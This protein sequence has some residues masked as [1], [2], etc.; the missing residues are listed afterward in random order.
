MKQFRDIAK[1]LE[2]ICENIVVDESVIS[3]KC[4]TLG[5][6]IRD[7]YRFQLNLKFAHGHDMD[8]NSVESVG[9][10]VSVKDYGFCIAYNQIL[11]KFSICSQAFLMNDDDAD[12]VLSVLEEFSNKDYSTVFKPQ[13]R[14]LKWN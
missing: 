9:L 11:Q 6:C 12:L 1:N 13:K 4:Y 2:H 10:F 7:G 14:K 8:S 3:K 5:K